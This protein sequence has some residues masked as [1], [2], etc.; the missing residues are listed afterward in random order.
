MDKPA[1]V[2]SVAVNMAIDQVHSLLFLV[3][4]FELT[5]LGIKVT[6]VFLFSLTLELVTFLRYPKTFN[7]RSEVHL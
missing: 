1:V 2:P 4:R 6:L 3:L 7:H 5:K